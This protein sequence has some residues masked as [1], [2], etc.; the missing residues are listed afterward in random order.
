L[1][2]W[3]VDVDDQRGEYQL[4]IGMAI[5][6]MGTFKLGLGVHNFDRGISGQQ[7]KQNLV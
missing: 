5:G 3:D 1:W 2:G 4:N 6:F 7:P